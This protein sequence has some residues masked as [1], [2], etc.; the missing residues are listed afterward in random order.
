[1]RVTL[2][3]RRH[4]VLVIAQVT[5]GLGLVVTAAISDVSTIGWAVGI[6]LALLVS[7]AL[8]AW[9]ASERVVRR[10][11]AALVGGLFGVCVGGAIGPVWL[12]TT[13]LSVVAVSGLA[14]LAA[15]LLLLASGAWLLIRATPGWWRLAAIPVAFLLLQFVVL[16]VAGAVYGTHPPPTPVDAAMPPSAERVSFETPDGVTMVG[17]YTPSTNGAAVIVL[18]GSGGSKAST[19]AHAAVLTDHGYGVLALDSRGTG[20][21]GG[22]GH[23]WGWHGV[24][25]VTGAVAWLGTRP[26]VDPERIAALGLSM[27]GEI[28]LTAAASGTGLAAVVAE[29]A[30]SRVPADLVYLPGDVSGLIQRLDGEIMWGLAGLMT[31]AAPPMPLTEAVAA[32]SDAMPVLLIVGQAS[33]EVMAAPLLRDAAPSMEVWELPDTPHIESLARHPEEW[34]TRVLGFLDAALGSA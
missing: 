20:D 1:M 15:G 3:W 27:G 6:V 12:A 21:S 4:A 10:G 7:L 32:T 33:D 17:W 31:D 26:E 11:L 5:V 13:G 28:A 22:L 9:T 8:L 34:E 29:G 25:D 23:A 18:P 24:A 30:S 2:P 16:P 14:A 19:L